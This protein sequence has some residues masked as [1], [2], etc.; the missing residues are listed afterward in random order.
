MFLFSLIYFLLHLHVIYN[1][2][3]TCGCSVDRSQTVKNSENNN[4]LESLSTQDQCSSEDVERMKY[5]LAKTA[6]RIVL[7]PSGVYQ[8]GTDDIIIENDA[9]GPKRMVQIDS[10]YLDKYEVSND[11]YMNFVTETNYK[12]EAESFGDSFVFGIFLNS[13]Y[14]EKLKDF[15]VVQAK[16]WYKVNGANWRQPYGPDSDIKGTYLMNKL[17][18]IFSNSMRNNII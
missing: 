2:E 3:T 9:E 11:E 7:I 4:P 15:R 14:K 8:L 10:F 12:T 16:W 17:L 13:T 5:R 6:N 18:Y 1:K